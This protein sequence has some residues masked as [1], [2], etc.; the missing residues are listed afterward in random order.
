M[1]VG[2]VQDGDRDRQPCFEIQRSRARYKDLTA[3]RSNLIMSDRQGVQVWPRAM[4][5][6][7]VHSKLP[8]ADPKASR[9][10]TKDLNRLYVKHQAAIKQ[11]VQ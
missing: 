9:E 11:P 2:Q 5:N 8:V 10:A 6:S 1:E 3:E 4:P 7:K